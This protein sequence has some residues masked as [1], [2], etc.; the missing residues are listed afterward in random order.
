MRKYTWRFFEI[1]FFKKYSWL[2]LHET[3]DASR[4]KMKLIPVYKDQ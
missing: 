2:F 4:L 1:D 3:P